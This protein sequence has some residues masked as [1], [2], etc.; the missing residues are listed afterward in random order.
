[1]TASTMIFFSCFVIVDGQPTVA[2][3]TDRSTQCIW[4]IEK[5]IRQSF[6]R[7]CGR[8]EQ[9]LIQTKLEIDSLMTCSR[10]SQSTT[11]DT[12]DPQKHH[13]LSALTGKPSSMTYEDS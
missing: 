9:L 13:L 10:C 1:M 12:R 11:T 4:N 3:E 8:T 6:G 7:S 2:D 5:Y